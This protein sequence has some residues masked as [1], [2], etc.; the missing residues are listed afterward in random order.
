MCD[1]VTCTQK[2]WSIIEQEPEA[3]ASSHRAPY[4]LPSLETRPD[5]K[6]A[7]GYF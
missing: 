5:S 4:K 6:D 2:T 3:V 1:Y 7:P